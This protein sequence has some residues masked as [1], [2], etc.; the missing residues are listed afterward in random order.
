MFR[1]KNDCDSG[2][3]TDSPRSS[4]KEAVPDTK[5]E[6]KSKRRNGSHY[7]VNDEADMQDERGYK[8]GAFDFVIIS[9]KMNKSQRAI[10][11]LL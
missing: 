6:I 1:E 9:F 4:P 8:C 7:F 3:E 10:Q 5:N 2:D 11:P